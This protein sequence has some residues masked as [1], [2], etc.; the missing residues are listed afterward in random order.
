[1]RIVRKIMVKGMI[2]VEWIAVKVMSKRFQ[3][4]GRAL[5]TILGEMIIKEDL[6]N[7]KK[8]EIEINDSSDRY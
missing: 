2:Q 5:Q 1:M 8:D 6:T 7:G 3:C 4:D